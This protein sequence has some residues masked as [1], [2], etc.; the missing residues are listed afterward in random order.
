VKKLNNRHTDLL[1]RVEVQQWALLKGKQEQTSNWYLIHNP[2]C[3]SGIKTITKAPP[4]YLKQ[5]QKYLKQTCL[6]DLTQEAEAE[7]EEEGDKVEAE[8]IPTTTKANSKW[9]SSCLTLLERMPQV[10]PQ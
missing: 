5:Q 6:E 10:M 8:V 4:Q 7:V 2:N 1:D 9:T 3:R